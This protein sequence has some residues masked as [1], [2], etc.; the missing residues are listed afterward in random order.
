MAN[1]R[2]L[3]QKQ[4]VINE[5]AENVKSAATVIWFDNNGLSVSE[6]TEL[7]RALKNSGCTLKVYKNTLTRRALETIGINIDE[8]LV[9]PKVMA[10]G[11]DTIEPIKVVNDFAKKIPALEIKVGIVDGEVTELDTLK[12]LAAIPS[13]DTLLTQIAAGLMGTVKDLVVALDL[14][15]NDLE[16]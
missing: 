6:Q 3:D 11:D 15:S 2:I 13:R 1:Q 4:D 10:F 5:I 12:K 8:S 14:Y 9:G 16:K 7:R